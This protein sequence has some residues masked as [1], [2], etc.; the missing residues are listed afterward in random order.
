MDT[1]EVELKLKFRIEVDQAMIDKLTHGL[2]EQ[3][4]RMIAL[5]LAKDGVDIERTSY[6]IRPIEVS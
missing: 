3:Y 6:S 2:S 5:E 4:I 1:N